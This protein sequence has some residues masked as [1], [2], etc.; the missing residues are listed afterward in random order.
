MIIN[1]GTYAV[2]VAKFAFQWRARMVNVGANYKEGGRIKFPTCPV[3]LNPTEYDSQQHLLVCKSVNINIFTNQNPSSYD[4]LF[5]KNLENRML[6]VNMLRKNYQKRNQLIK[7]R[8]ETWNTNLILVWVNLHSYMFIVFCC[9]LVCIWSEIIYIY[10][11][12][13]I[14]HFEWILLSH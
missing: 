10:I 4:D 8:N 2:E 1:Q 5:G 13:Y 7:E 3:C 11:Y 9:T 14:S 12:S 6:V